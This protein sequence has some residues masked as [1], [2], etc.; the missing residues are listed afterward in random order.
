VT[1]PGQVAP[2]GAFVIGGGDYTFGQDYTNDI[3]K[4]LFHVNFPTDLSSAVD[5]LQEYLLKMPIEALRAFKDVI[6]GSVDD[7][8]ADALTAISTIIDNIQD[9]PVFL[10]LNDF[11]SWVGEFILN[12]LGHVGDLL[13]VKWWANN[14]LSLGGLIPIG[15]LTDK[16]VNLL[17]DPDFDDS[18]SV[19]AL[20]GWSWDTNQVKVVCDGYNKQMFQRTRVAVD[21]GFKLNLSGDVKTVSIAGT[22][23]KVALEIVEYNGDALGDIVEV[24]SRTTAATSYVT[25]S[26][27]Y[28]VPAGVTHVVVALSVTNATS[29]TVYFDKLNLHRLNKITTGFVEGLQGAYDAFNGFVGDVLHNAGAVIG[30]IAG[31]VVDTIGNTL[32][33]IWDFIV[34]GISGLSGL[35]SGTKGSDIEK[36][37]LDLAANIASM[38]SRITALQ[39]AATNGGF[40]G[41]SAFVDFSPRADATSMGSDFTQSYAGSGTATLGIT[42]GRAAWGGTWGSSGR[43][44][45][46]IYNALQTQT[47]YQRVGIAFA[48]VPTSGAVNYIYGRG[49]AAANEGVFVELTPTTC[50]LGCVASGSVTYF[51]TSTLYGTFKA[52]AVYYLE[53]GTTGGSNIFKVYENDRVI[54]TYTDSGAVSRVGA[55]YRYTWAAGYYP[56]SGGSHGTPG[57][58]AAFSMSDNTPKAILGSGFRRYRASTS[59]VSQAS[60]VNKIAASFFD[61]ADLITDD[62]T[63]NGTN[64]KVTVSVS[65]WYIIT[66]KVRLASATLSTGGKAQLLLYVNNTAVQAG[67]ESW[68][69]GPTSWGGSDDTAA[70]FVQYLNAGDYVEPGMSTD[71]AINITGGSAGVQTNYSVVFLNNTK[72]KN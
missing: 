45:V 63:Y 18:A 3:V 56:A 57:Q 30:N 54:L 55:S 13:D 29:G 19:T 64:N 61:T 49:N 67:W 26:G 15:A 48:S 37:G 40:S 69:T 43:T 65:G 41:N 38:Q 17:L 16:P 53:C 8:F 35:F 62:L 72:P 44:C 60:G 4:Q 47:D 70:T 34:N 12:I 14:I 7:D 20:D 59:N 28:T 6:P 31:V 21:E 42:S 25:I 24:C 5:I 58:M 27:D 39:T 2:D 71:R 10:L 32:Q 9:S 11:T 36:V 46:A 23:W 33:N 51:A 22:S 50:K 1:S 68:Y 52:G 66:L